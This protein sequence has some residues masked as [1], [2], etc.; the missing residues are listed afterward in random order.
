MI[1][2]L[3]DLTLVP[4]MLLVEPI[5]SDN[6]ASSA[7][8]GVLDQST[9]SEQGLGKVVACTPLYEE[10]PD[11]YDSGT[12]GPIG[13]RVFH[14]RNPKV[15]DTIVFRRVSSQEMVLEGADGNTAKYR[16]ISQDDIAGFIDHEP[17]QRSPQTL[18]FRDPNE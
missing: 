1:Y 5:K 12:S 11:T 15:G 13:V 8:M 3:S 16:V 18:Y 14:R 6:S 7:D 17:E 2:K 9:P 4:G 10:M